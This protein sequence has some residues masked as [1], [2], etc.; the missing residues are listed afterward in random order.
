MR[1]ESRADRCS[2]GSANSSDEKKSRKQLVDEIAELRQQLN[3]KDRSSRAKGERKRAEGHKAAR[4]IPARCQS[5]HHLHHP[6]LG[7]FCCTFVSEN[8]HAIMGYS[9]EEMTTDPKCWPDHLHPDDAAAGLRRNGPA[10]RTGRRNRRISLPASGR[11][12]HLDPGYLQGRRMTR[13]AIRWSSSA[14]GPTLPS[15]S[16]RSRR[17]SRPMSSC[18][19]RSAT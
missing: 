11:A 8:L 7:R 16:R 1:G 13:P 9:P 4:A 18:K 12:L 3:A 5:R 17:L 14:P 15:A 19:R 2:R 10:D 6:G